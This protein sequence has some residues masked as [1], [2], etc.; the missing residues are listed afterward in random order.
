MS[1]GLVTYEFAPTL[2]PGTHLVSASF[3]STYQSPKPAP[4]PSSSVTARLW[5]WEHSEWV[6]FANFNTN[7]LTDIPQAAINPSSG[8]VRLQMK[9]DAPDQFVF[10]QIFLKGTVQ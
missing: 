7:G 6:S 10:G 9:V 2:V 5:D 4:A 8:M 3:D 1:K